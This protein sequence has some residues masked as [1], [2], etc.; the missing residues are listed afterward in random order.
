[1]NCKQAHLQARRRK[2]TLAAAAMGR[3]LLD[4]FMRVFFLLLNAQKLAWKLP[5]LPV[6]QHFEQV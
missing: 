1:V 3:V 6:A 2:E 5:F 4:F